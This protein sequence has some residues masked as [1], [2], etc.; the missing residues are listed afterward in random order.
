MTINKVDIVYTWVDGT[1]PVWQEKKQFHLNS[2][3][4]YQQCQNNQIG[5]KRYLH[6]NELKYS[7]RS[8]CQF[9]EWVNHIYIITDNQS[10]AWLK[11]SNKLTIIDHKDIIPEQ[12]LP[13]FNS[14]V[15]ES[16][17][18]K[19]PNLSEHFIYFNDDMML[20][21]ET[22]ISDFFK[23]DMPKLFTSSI[24]QSRKKI[25]E[26]ATYNMLAIKNSRNKIKELTGS[27]V[28]YGLRHGIRA[29]KKSRLEMVFNLYSKDVENWSKEKFR[30]T[31]FS[32][33]YL[34]SFHDIVKKEMITCYQKNLKSSNSMNLFPTFCYINNDNILYFS[35]NFEKLSP[36]VFC[37]NET[38]IPLEKLPLFTT[39]KLSHKSEF[40]L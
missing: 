6:H 16:Y 10:P 19:I 20:G 15:I 17:L 31:P 3:E 39:G 36:L 25:K 32:L 22:S 30:L 8:L 28:N 2:E 29:I 27:C 38:N 5:D 34:Y 26:N 1:D 4:G 18:H 12:L 23:K 21:K 13:T 37:I 7:L 11:E 40:E 9:A 14:S 24:F 35:S 33:L